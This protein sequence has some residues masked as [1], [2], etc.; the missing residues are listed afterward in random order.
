MALQLGH[1]NASYLSGGY[2]APP[3]PSDTPLGDLLGQ[4]LTGLLED[5]GRLNGRLCKVQDRLRGSVPRAGYDAAGPVSP[6][7]GLLSK[8]DDIA[9]R[10][11][12][13]IAY[14]EETVAALEAI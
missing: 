3:A 12:N 11:R 13:E 8:Y 1:V 9:N 10:L 7:A 2:A 5:I 14:L 4:R 6:D